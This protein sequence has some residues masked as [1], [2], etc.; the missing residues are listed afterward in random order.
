MNY[1]NASFLSF[2]FLA[3]KK[4]AFPRVNLEELTG[5]EKLASANFVF[6]FKS[7][8]EMLVKI[9]MRTTLAMAL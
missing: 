8:R 4:D 1:C 6:F 3:G 5:L 2:P 9:T 7:N